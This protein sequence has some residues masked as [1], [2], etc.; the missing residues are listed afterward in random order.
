MKSFYL[1][2]ILKCSKENIMKHAN[3]FFY[4][5]NEKMVPDKAVIRN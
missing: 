1:W 3:F 4:S 5:V 2:K